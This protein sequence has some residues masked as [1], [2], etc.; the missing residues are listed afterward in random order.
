[1]KTTLSCLLTLLC[2]LFVYGETPGL[3]KVKHPPAKTIVLKLS[4]YENWKEI[5]RSVSEN[6]GMV[7]RIPAGQSIENWSELICIQYQKFDN[8]KGLCIEDLVN[9]FRKNTLNSYPGNKVSWKIIDNSANAIIYEWILHKPYK[10]I[11]PQH[12]I[13]RIFLTK[14]GEFHRIG[15]TRQHT[16]M[17]E[18]ERNKWIKSLRESTNVV[19]WE[20]A[21]ADDG[22][23]MVNKLIANYGQYTFAYT[24]IMPKNLKNEEIVSRKELLE[25]ICIQ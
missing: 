11:P 3:V 16:V 9:E 4:G 24:R 19:P 8:A 18:E 23:S 2:T 22:L 17:T 14:N 1:M 20:Q 15:F 21:A 13:A 10:D 25:S 12:E 6:S 7:E 5:S